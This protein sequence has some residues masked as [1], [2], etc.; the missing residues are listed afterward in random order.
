MTGEDIMKTTMALVLVISMFGNLFG[1]LFG[2]KKEAAPSGKAATQA[3]A[4][5]LTEEEFHNAMLKI[6]GAG[7]KTAGSDMLVCKLTD[8]TKQKT[9]SY[10]RDYIPE[11]YLTDDPS[12]VGGVVEITADYKKVPYGLPALKKFDRD[13]QILTVQIRELFTGNVLAK[14]Q[15]EGKSPSTASSAGIDYADKKEITQWIRESWELLKKDYSTLLSYNGKIN[16]FRP[17]AFG[18]KI[19]AQVSALSGE[20]VNMYVPQYVPEKLMA[21]SAE[22]VGALLLVKE[23]YQNASE[24]FL[25][26]DSLQVTLRI[27]SPGSNGNTKTTDYATETFQA[28]KDGK[29]NEDAIKAW[30]QKQWDAAVAD[31]TVYIRQTPLKQEPAAAA[32]GDDFH[33]MMQKDAHLM[34]Q[35][36]KANKLVAFNA[37]TGQYIKTYIPSKYLAKSPSEVALVVKVWEENGKARFYA[38][39]PKAP[40]KHLFGLTFEKP[41]AGIDKGLVSRELDRQFEEYLSGK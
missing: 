15:F 8:T 13:R 40:D 14:G 18:G 32:T 38:V 16:N 27:Y 26:L 21:Q 7:K 23:S 11:E 37:A 34:G 39:D 9:D 25:L 30:V 29:V 36:P 20:G 3:V 41:L 12:L 31:K 24:A 1:G 33:T 35:D 10:T 28:D 5:P 4:A 2:N 19:V 22:E 17:D 6:P